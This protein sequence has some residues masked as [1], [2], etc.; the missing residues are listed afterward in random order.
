MS[1]IDISVPQSRTET[2]LHNMNGESYPLEP[3]RSRVEAL[4]QEI[5]ESGGGG[6]GGSGLKIHVCSSSEYDSNG[7][8]T[9][10]S[11]SGST[12]YLVPVGTAGSSNAF[13]E[14]IYVNNAWEIF[15]DASV[16]ISELITVKETVS[17]TTP[18]I[19][20]TKNHLYL[21]G[22]ILS[23]DFTPSIEGLCEVIFKS[24][25]TPTV[26]TIPQ[27]VIMPEWFVVEANKT[28]EISILDGK[29]GAV[30][31]WS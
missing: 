10:A 3:P 7:K 16:D 5:L 9:V 13:S 24:G 28:Y 1:D 11:P 20:A 25:T 15:G 27:T 21:C 31:S 6:E 2:I 30:M 17:G 29:Y 23:L 26:L 4:L 18:S 12:I 22:E 14:W 8:P 19:S